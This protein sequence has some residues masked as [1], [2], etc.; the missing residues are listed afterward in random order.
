MEQALTLDAKNGNALW[1]DAISKELE[2]VTVAF[3]ILPDGT[4][5]FIGCQFVQGPKVFNK[6]RLVAGGKATITY[7]I[8]VCHERQ[9]E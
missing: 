7:D 5:A 8:V 3:K 1:V 9:T 6:S 2:N 4:K